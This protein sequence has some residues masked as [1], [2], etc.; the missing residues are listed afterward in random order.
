MAKDQ[1]SRQYPTSQFTQFELE[2]NSGAQ[3]VS[4]VV[5]PSGTAVLASDNSPIILEPGGMAVAQNGYIR[6]GQTGFN[7]GVGWFIGNSNGV[8]KLSIGNPSTRYISWDGTTLT[9]NGYVISG[10]GAFAGD[11]SDGNL[12]IT[13]GTTTLNLGAARVYV[14]N[15]NSISITGTGA[16]AFSNPHSEGTIIILK[17]FGSA[18]FSSSTVP[19]VDASGMG[20]SEG[21]KGQTSIYLH[22]TN[23][24]GS[25]NG[26]GGGTPGTGGAALSTYVPDIALKVVPIAC[27]AGGGQAD[28]NAGTNANSPGGGGG[29]L[30]NAG[31]NGQSN[32]GGFQQNGHGSAGGGGLYFE[33]GGTFT[34]SATMSVAGVVGQDSTPSTGAF[35]GGGGGAGGSIVI[36][37]NTLGSDTGTYTV[38][39]GLGGN[40]AAHKGGNGGD[41]YSY[42]TLNTAFA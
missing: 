17:C 40:Q 24:G 23:N 22:Q 19:C 36:L 32:G 15:Y 33:I 11:G 39:G 9:I 31:T 14:K 21:V 1:F 30:T 3:P 2:A 20:A 38:T 25:G 42:R 35:S 26:A 6:S 34:C 16:L 28:Y 8:P 4:T 18:V 13:S 41:G 7:T 37:Y 29:S 12:S 5:G 27:G 10:K